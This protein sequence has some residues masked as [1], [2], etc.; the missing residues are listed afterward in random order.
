[1]ILN[2]QVTKKIG[3]GLQFGLA[4]N[5]HKLELFKN[6]LDNIS[7]S[8]LDKTVDDVYNALVRLAPLYKDQ[9]KAFAEGLVT[10]CKDP[11]MPY[12]RFIEHKIFDNYKVYMGSEEEE[13]SQAIHDVSILIFRINK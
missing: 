11:E 5:K 8:E 9:A 12:S 7:R 6:V 1:M 4:I 2:G 10:L 3:K 13:F